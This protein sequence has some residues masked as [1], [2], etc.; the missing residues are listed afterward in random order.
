M[1]K[2][3]GRI[4]TFL[5]MLNQYMMLAQTTTICDND[6]G[7]DFLQGEDRNDWTS[8]PVQSE[9][10][11]HDF[12]LAVIPPNGGQCGYF[13][14]INVC[15]DLNSVTINPGADPSCNL[16]GVY[17]NIWYN[18]P[19]LNNST[20]MEQRDDEIIGGAGWSAPNT[21]CFDIVNG[22]YDICSLTTIGVDVVP[23]VDPNSNSDCPTTMAIT[24]G[25]VTIDYDVCIDYTYSYTAPPLA[26]AGADQVISCTGC[27]DVGADPV[28]AEGNSYGWSNG[29]MGVLE[30]GGNPN[31][32]DNGQILNVCPTSST[33]YILTV[34]DPNTCCTNT[35]EVEITVADCCSAEAGIINVSKN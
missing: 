1:S 31:D 30:W 3:I 26:D 24:A 6:N 2:S 12:P 32:D 27:V 34:T 23:A 10:Y 25:F 9:G 21:Y 19:D 5:L 14:S 7:V 16:Q 17:G 4:L 28:S 18:P 8:D 35:D 20:S 33:T 15:I 29:Q 22:G 13:T 11:M